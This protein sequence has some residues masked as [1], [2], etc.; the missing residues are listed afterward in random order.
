MQ[1]LI[2]SRRITTILLLRIFKKFIKE[3]DKKNATTRQDLIQ[4][5][6]YLKRE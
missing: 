5:K 2:Y 6:S 1:F 4:M 3:K